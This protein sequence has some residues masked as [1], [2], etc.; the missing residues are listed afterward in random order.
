MLMRADFLLTSKTAVRLYD[1]VKSL[2]IIDYHN[3]LSLADLE[4]NKRFFE[5]Y[6]LWIKPDPYKHRAMRMCGVP[7]KYITGAAKNYEKFV[8][9]CETLPRLLGNP[10]YDWSLMELKTVFGIDELP[11]AKNAQKIYMYCNEYL[12]NNVV[13]AK[14]LLQKFNVEFACPCAS[15]VDDIRMFEGNDHIFPSL[16]G[17]DLISPAPE[18]INKLGRITDI[19]ISDTDSFERAVQKQLDEFC[20]YGLVFADHA[21][22]NGFIFEKNAA[23]GSP[24]YILEFLG[25]EYSRRNIIMQLHLGAQRY[26]STRLRA[27]AGAAGGFAA[28]GNSIDICSL[29]ALLDT[30][31]MSEYG[32]PGTVLFTLNPADNALV[33]V[34]SGSYSKDGVSG[35]VTQGPAWW[36]CDHKH[37]ITDMLE[38]TAAFSV[39]S[40]FPGMTTDSRSFLSFV[41]HDYFRRILC[42]WIGQKVENG[43]FICSE[44]HLKDLIFKLCYGNAKTI[45]NNRKEER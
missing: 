15:L 6:D 5:L 29:T 43:A 31:D 34:L 36:W 33:S 35:L 37:G 8:K 26:T 42:D 1:S 18:L 30:L 14:S 19:R 9:W 41:R 2:P 3:H 13:S 22:D 38:N 25:K 16:R 12:E 17:D 44:D 7:E 28:I 24:S 45:I 32:L 40:N 10:L 23:K 20:R 11:S 27:A 21:L 39:L 4:Q